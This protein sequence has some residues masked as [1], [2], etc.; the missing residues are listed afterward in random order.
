MLYTL[1]IL[2]VPCALRG[3]TVV[4]KL[5]NT[6]SEKNGYASSRAK[7]VPGYVMGALGGKKTVSNKR[8]IMESFIKE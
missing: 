4:L 3:L 8:R 5:K 7:K 1:V 6:P 2:P